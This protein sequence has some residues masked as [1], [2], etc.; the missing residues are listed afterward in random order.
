MDRLAAEGL[1]VTNA[2]SAQPVCSPYRAQ[3]MTGRY[4]HR[5]Y[6]EFGTL[7][8][9]EI[10]FAHVLQEAGYRTCV[11]GKWQLAGRVE[12]AAYHGEGTLPDQAG[13]DEHCLWQVEQLG[14]RY[15]DPT[16]QVNG[17]LREQIAGAYG[18]DICC[19]YLI[20]FMHRS[21]DRPFFAYY[22]MI[23]P[24]NPFQPT[25]A[26]DVPPGERTNTDRRFF[27]D[28]VARVD[29]LAGR[30]SGALDDLGLREDTLLLFTTDN[31]TNRSITSRRGDESV[32]GGKGLP[33]TTGM[34]VPL[35][36][37]RPGFTPAGGVNDDLIDF[38]DF[39]PTLAELAGAP[40]PRDRVIDGRSFLPQLRGR[41][42]YPR[43]WI[44]SHY[45]P[46]WGGWEP[47]RFAR[48]HRYKLTG[49]GCFYD[50]LND[51]GEEHPIGIEHLTGENRPA[52]EKFSGVLENMR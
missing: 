11:T 10:T 9:G 47:G 51:P 3:L 18:P 35:I 6:T 8:P 7:P 20:D 38:S 28:M 36:A 12:G 44:F 33:L 16:L 2:I 42:G 32:A 23:L 19:D 5:N 39:L 43:E 29:T 45:E 34:H 4:N 25:P 41:R 48:D 14:Q 22:P 17:E 37:S 49:E 24:H 52:Y 27:A 26:S 40:L 46:K 21:T 15:W 1:L 50:L 30:I 31:G 13:F